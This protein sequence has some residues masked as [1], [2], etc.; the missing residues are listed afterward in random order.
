MSNRRE[1]LQ[2][3][4]TGALVLGS[5]SNLGLAAMLDQHSQHAETG[6]SKVVVARDP[7]V[8]DSGTQLD[9]K[10]VLALLDRAMAAYTGR[11]NPVEAWKHIVPQG[12]V[13]G[14]KTN[15]LGGKGISTHVMLVLAIAERLQQAGVKPGNIVVWDRNARDLQACGLTINTD[16][17]RV[18]CFGSDVAGYEEQPV[19]WGMA[20][21]HLSKI[22]TRE[23]GMVIGLPILKDHE[24]SGITFAM[25]NM[26]GVVSRPQDLHAG[27]C[28][29][30]V[31]DLNCIPAI[32]EKVRFTIGDALSSVYD[33]GPGFHPEHLWYPNALV[34]GEDRVA[35]DHTAWQMIERK[36]AEVGMKPLEAAGRPPRYIATAADHAH[37]LG[38]NDPR[39]INLMEI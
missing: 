37:N 3:A 33:G 29:P 22:L 9:E 27:G 31:A 24:M 19:A 11:E 15:G 14:L 6:K 39:R 25:K 5:Q 21:V 2:A 26:Y 38:V 17:S 7:A 23:C 34:V 12:Q 35:V 18:R 8:H 1:F 32:R 4:A 20:N 30:G 28:N 10:R 13:I 36:R 16:P